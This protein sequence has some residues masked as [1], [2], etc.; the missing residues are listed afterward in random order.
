MGC[1][2]AGGQS[3]RMGG[4]DKA[5]AILGEKTLLERTTTRLLNQVQHVIINANGDTTKHRTLGLPVIG[6]IISGNQGPLAGVLTAMRFAIPGFSHVITVATDTPFFP[7]NLVK[8][9]ALE[10]N[11]ENTIIM[12]SSEGHHHPVFALW[13]VSLADDLQSWLKSTKHPKIMMWA[14]RHPVK[15]VSFS[16]QPYDPFFNINTPEELE[17]AHEKLSVI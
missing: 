11:E 6:D 9:L 3:R 14:E 10:I 7:N 15:K 1:I 2:L 4:I 8:T 16:V 5:F 12:A 17:K 13:P